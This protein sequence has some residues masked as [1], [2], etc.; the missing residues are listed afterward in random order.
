MTMTQ[1][2]AA[3]RP[4]APMPEVP[5]TDLAAMAREVWP[6][7]QDRFTEALVTAKYIGGEPVDSFER[8][9]AEYCQTT[10][11]VGT[12]NGTD[13]VQ[14]ALEALEIGRGDEVIVPANTFIAT[15]EAVI[16]AGA[17]PRFADVD[18]E[19][20][21]L[22]AETFEPALTS[23]T[24]A[25]IAVHLYGQMVD[26]TA[27]CAAAERV[28]VLVV[29]DAAQ[30]HG[31]E[32]NGRRAG[33]F[34]AVGCFS[35]YPG[36]N[37]G[38]FGDAGAV[39]TSDAELADRVRC[40]A[41]HGRAGGSAHY[42]HELV[43]MNSRLD[44]LQAIALS[45]KLE[46]NEAWTAALIALAK[47]YRAMLAGSGVRFVARAPQ[48][49][50]VYHLFVVRVADRARTQAELAD[51]GIRAGV[52]YPVPCHK[53]PPLVRYAD[54]PLPVCEQSAGE[55]LS[56]PL[57]PHMTW[58]QLERVSEVVHELATRRRLD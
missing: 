19:T 30:A 25:V 58:E 44:A 10:Y 28:G 35:F 18:P 31:A 50:H 43:G 46:R 54:G 8:K 15:V 48:A 1:N 9:W 12:A 24:R 34:G 7:I 45:A 41:N 55:L 49:R 20:L 21:L 42:E 38:A 14:L 47:E 6:A 53:Q 2:T 22:T 16:R 5:F 57:F 33:S 13:A 39:V 32:W 4:G 37:I 3:A 27:L 26:M 17:T 51:K 23:R 11:A 56:L 29:E 52:H 36:K 40:L